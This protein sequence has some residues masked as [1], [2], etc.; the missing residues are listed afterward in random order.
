MLY[1]EANLTEREEQ[2][3]DTMIYVFNPVLKFILMASNYLEFKRYGFNSCRQ[4]A[5]LGAGYLK[6]LLPDYT[7]TVYEGSFV[8]KIN[9]QATPYEHAFIIANKDKRNLIIDLSRTTKRL[10]FS[11]VTDM[12]YPE[13]EDYEDVVKI[14][15]VRLDLD[16]LLNTEEP[17]YF[18][19]QKPKKLLEMIMYLTNKLKSF[20]KEKQLEFCDKIYKETTMLRR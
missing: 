12:S 15:Q 10:L 3:R 20:P 16:E 2:A 5:I 13:I 14:G 6:T 17:E 7:F 4:T 1:F 9:G 19:G 8:E 11:E 18:T